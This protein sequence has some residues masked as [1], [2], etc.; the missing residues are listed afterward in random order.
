M[1]AGMVWPYAPAERISDME[2]L[3]MNTTQTYEAAAEHERN[4][5]AA[6]DDEA[7]QDDIKA[8]EF[9]KSDP[10][11]SAYL[12]DRA[13]HRRGMAEHSRERAK[14]YEEASRETGA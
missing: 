2:G 6:C 3:P 8:K 5:A 10:L 13:K 4:F 11:W 12:S 7:A 1:G 14:T 9:E